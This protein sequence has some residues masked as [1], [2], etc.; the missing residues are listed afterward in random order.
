MSNQY[1]FTK[2]IHSRVT[3]SLKV[4]IFQWVIYFQCL[5]A[6]GLSLQLI[7][8]CTVTLM[9]SVCHV[10]QNLPEEIKAWLHNQN[11][12][13]TALFIFSTNIRNFPRV[14]ELADAG[15]PTWQRKQECSCRRR[16]RMQWF[17]KKTKQ[18][19]KRRVNLGLAVTFWWAL[20]VLRELKSSNQWTLFL[21]Q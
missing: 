4:S 21:G 10:V 5:H 8:T 1:Q 2:N 3:D 18:N 17:K 15:N 7:I 6:L 13:R 12:N 11:R 19:S 9:S 14:A 16:Q 20:L